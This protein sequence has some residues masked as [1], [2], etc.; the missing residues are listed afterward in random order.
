MN[1]YEEV[2]GVDAIKERVKKRNEIKL[3][4]LYKH[5]DSSTPEVQLR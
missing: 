2:V 3:Q 5:I 4:N 1:E